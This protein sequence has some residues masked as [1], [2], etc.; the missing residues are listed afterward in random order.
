MITFYSRVLAIWTKNEQKKKKNPLNYRFRVMFSRDCKCFE[1][2]PCILCHFYR[3]YNISNKNNND[4]HC[5][6]FI[7]LSKKKK[8]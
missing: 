5:S 1:L 3:M 2:K 4:N 8:N 6:V 7:T